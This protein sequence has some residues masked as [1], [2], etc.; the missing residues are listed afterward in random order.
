MQG[1]HDAAGVLK[2]RQEKAEGAAAVA[3]G[4]P[5]SGAAVEQAA[6]EDGRG[7]EADVDGV[8]EC[9]LKLLGADEAFHA[10]RADG[11]NEDGGAEPLGLDEKGL[12]RRCAD[13]HAVDV[14]A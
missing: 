6:R 3:E 8:A 13:G 9:L 14:A 7:G 11:V 10:G 5:E 2:P 1:G 4:D 12:E